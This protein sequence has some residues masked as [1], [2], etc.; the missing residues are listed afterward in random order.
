MQVSICLIVCLVLM[1]VEVSQAN[2]IT[3]EGYGLSQ[4][5]MKRA[6]PCGVEFC[7]SYKPCCNGNACRGGRC[8]NCAGQICKNTRECCLDHVCSYKICMRRKTN[9]GPTHP[10]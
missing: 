5:L 3:P 9:G 1:S 6:V 10:V 2:E 8:N 4:N 7:T